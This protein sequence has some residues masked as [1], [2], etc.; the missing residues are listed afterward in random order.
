M[1]SIIHIPRTVAVLLILVFTGWITGNRLSAETVIEVT[2]DPTTN[3]RGTYS[4]SNLQPLDSLFVTD[5]GIEFE[6]SKASGTTAPAYYATSEDIRL[7]ANNELNVTSRNT[8][9][10]IDFFVNYN[11]KTDS[12]TLVS[13]YGYIDYTADSLLFSWRRRVVEDQPSFSIKTGKQFRIKSIRITL[14]I[15][16]NVAILKAPALSQGSCDFYQDFDLTIT[17]L[18]SPGA[19]IMYTLDG[20]TPSKTNGTIYTGP[21]KIS[22]GNDVTVKA[23][24]VSGNNVSAV[25]SATYHYIAKYLLSLRLTNKNALTPEKCYYSSNSEYGYYSSNPPLYITGGDVVYFEYPLNRSYKVK[26]ITVNSTPVLFSNNNFNFIMPSKATE[27]VIDAEFAPNSPEDPET[28]PEDTTSYY[29]LTVVSNPTGAYSFGGPQKF[30]GGEKTSLYAYS[31]SGYIFTGWSIDGQTI[32]TERSL[33]FTMPYSDVVLTA[34]YVYNPSSP[35]EPEQPAL[36]HPLTVTASPQNS[37]TFSK[38]GSE[39]KFGE[40]YYVYAYPRDGYKMKGWIVNGVGIETTDTEYHGV[41]TELGAQIVALL[42][43]DPSSPGNP[44]ANNFNQTTGQVIID[45]FTEGDLSIALSNLVGSSNYPNVSSIIVKGKMNTADYRAVRNLTN[46]GTIDLSRVGGETTLPAYAFQSM[47]ASSILLPSTI[48]QMGNRAF[49]DCANLTSLTIY[50]QEPP[51]CNSVTFSNFTNKEN[52]TIFVPA[53]AVALYSQAEYWKDFTILPIG[54]DAH[55]LQ[56]NLP[57]IANDGRFKNYSL[58]I[59]NIVSGVRQKY[60]ISDRLLYT[61]NGLQKDEQYNIYL[62]SQSGLEVGRIEA[63]TIPDSDIAV[64]FD[65]I[66]TLHTI[67]AQVLTK[68]GADLTSQVTIEWLQPLEDGS[69]T[70]LRKAAS[71]SDIPD[72]QQLICRV[73]LDSKLGVVYQSPEDILY[74]V[75][76]NDNICSITLTPFRNVNL[77]GSIVDNDGVALSGASVSVSQLLNGKYTKTYTAK[78]DRKGVWSAMVIDAPTTYITYSAS[79]YVNLN[80]TIGN[81]DANVDTLD[82]GKRKLKSIVGARITY[83]FTYHAAG[84]DE[85][86]TFYSDHK[87]VAISVYN[88]TQ[89][90]QL[91]ETSLQYP[92]LIILDENINER[93]QLRLT[94]TSKTGAFSPIEMMVTIDDN[95]RAEVTFDIIGKGGITASFEMTENPSVIAML[96]NANNELLK[97]STYANATITFSD[98]DDGNYTLVSMGQSDLMSSVLRLS[99]FAEI[100]LS[101]DKDFVKNSVKVERGKLTEVKISEVPAF[102]ESLFFYTNSSTAFST[103]K[104]S[105]TT[106]NYLTLR[107]VI[108]FKGVYKSNISNVALVVDLPEACDFVEQSVILGPNLLPYTLD[109]NRLTIQLGKYYNSQTRFCVIPTAGGTFNATASV[110]FDYN[111]KTITQPI[112]SAIATIKDIEISTPSVI[113]SPSFK[114]SGTALG[115]SSINIYEDGALLGSGKANAAGLWNVECELANPYNLSTHSIYAEITTP[116]NTKLQSETKTITYDVNALQVSKVTMYH[117]NPELNGW[118]GKMETS[119]FDFLNPKTSATQWT[120]YYPNKKFT[121]TIEFTSNDPNRISNVVLY[122]HTA[123]GKFVPVNASYDEKKGFWYAEIDMGHSSDGYYPVN[124]SVDFDYIATYN[125]E[126]VLSQLESAQNAEPYPMVNIECNSLDNNSFEL[127]V[128]GD[129][130]D[131]ILTTSVNGLD[132]LPQDCVTDTIIDG[133][134]I[135]HITNLQAATI[136]YIFEKEQLL[137]FESDDEFTNEALQWITSI[138][139]KYIEFELLINDKARNNSSTNPPSKALSMAQMV[140]TSFYAVRT[141]YRFYQFSRT[142]QEHFQ[143]L[144]ELD[145]KLEAMTCIDE[146]IKAK[147]KELINKLFCD[148]FNITITSSFM[149]SGRFPMDSPLYAISYAGGWLNFAAEIGFSIQFQKINYYINDFGRECHQIITKI[150]GNHKTGSPDDNV[151]ID[152]SG[153]VYE[154]VPE[155]RVEGVQASIY[156]KETKYDMYGDPYEEVILWNAEEYAQKNPLFTDEN[157]MYR[158]DVPQ[159]LWQVK[160]EKDGYATAYSEWLPVPPPQLDVNI[161]ITQSKQPEVIEARAYEEGIEVEFDK[162]MDMSTL[163]ADNIYVTSLENKLEGTI[164]F[165]NT[166]LADEYASEDDVNA[167]RYASRVRFIPAAP[168]SSNAG[169]IRLTISR[170]V[171]SYAGIPMAE[172]YTQVLDVEKEVQSIVTEDE[173]MKVLYGGEK[174]ITVYAL[175]FDAAM[176]RTL[177]ITNSSDMIATVDVTEATLDDEGKAV[178]KVKGELPGCS[179][180]TFSIDDV[181]VTGSC[182]IDVVTEII[183][184]EAP[185]ASRASGTAVFRGTKIELSTDSKD[186]VIYFTTDGSCPCDEDGTRRKYSVPVVINEDTQILAITSTGDEESD[187]IEFNYTIKKANIDYQMAEGWTWISHSFDN[188][189]GI[190]QLTSD[191][192]VERILSQTQEV[193]RDPQLGMIGNL[194]TLKASESYKVET[195]AAT[196]L[197]RL[198]DIAR[199]PANPININSGWNW[200]GYPVTQTMSVD[201]AFEATEAESGDVIVGQSGFA[202]FD[203]E[204][205]IGTLATMSPGM[206]YMYQSV[207]PKQVVYNTSIVSKAAAMNITGISNN[208]GLVLDIH[209]YGLIMPVIATIT[210]LDGSLLDNDDYQVAAFCGSE[211]RGIGR[212]INGL[213]MLNVYGNTNDAITFQITD[214]EGKMMYAN[215]VSL[216]FSETVVGNLKA[217]FAIAINNQNGIYGVNYDGNIKVSIFGDMLHI[218]GIAT[219]NIDLVEIYDINGQKLMHETTVSESGIRVSSLTTGIYVVIVNGNG[220]YTYHKVVVR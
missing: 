109:N 94:A 70:Y 96:Y 98:L 12:T 165:I 125:K 162:Y 186:A 203:G 9:L 129:D 4:G 177:R 147:I 137:K 14:D 139:N 86:E 57:E 132:I 176:G 90:R 52:C 215:N 121:Y 217:P 135:R 78:T 97:K 23:A 11:S 62:Y 122:V 140:G 133:L 21:V 45:D 88:V 199:N 75:T 144:V 83:G 190:D 117:W 157:G 60:V 142:A 212:V 219:E 36:M 160:F 145:E 102:D 211:C 93:D 214:N 99:N 108:D 207:S 173:T 124:C 76:A 218:S 15:D 112:G 82:L 189:L 38:S 106:G 42:K 19:T 47:S 20:S 87:N 44:G 209:K 182:A 197:P 40:E 114:V 24:A 81:F 72:G 91:N 85:V 195:S 174:V 33:N 136:S 103:N 37:A 73:S 159:G 55:T 168:L 92:L 35:G 167:Q 43:F 5:Y 95:Q 61:F 56:V 191:S 110:V 46:A 69:T 50:A 30:A 152:P 8:I 216:N 18:N 141:A 65:D 28:T 148:Y 64:S 143:Q 146:D 74:T 54:T 171:R 27:I 187:V 68:D 172:T 208:N 48:T 111:G 119:V 127:L 6:F 67:S 107:S 80:D 31:N 206:G 193:V 210:S 100:G 166:A 134:D 192:G 153:Y 164:E 113:A 178:I 34:N 220:E 115:N 118:K 116:D 126:V 149:Q 170:N 205:W 130:I 79:E 29:S 194:S 63:V 2:P 213:V 105:I 13:N 58:E 183:T 49:T 7:Y 51:V 181:T 161:G 25:V 185:K 151:R 77:T 163:T 201:E 131:V 10:A 120:V 16:E 155:N 169:E 128:N 123:D 184:A 39:I 196:T 188:D 202:Q 1:K 104:S 17:D 154:A 198:N 158:W 156:Y 32:S 71:I 101:E 66:K 41:M 204:N 150:G 53:S 3:L 22:G 138:N 200:L 84:V 59:V 180:L 179:Q 89:N 26:N 175:P